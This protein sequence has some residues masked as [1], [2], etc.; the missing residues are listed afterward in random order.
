MNSNNHD[1][2]HNPPNLTFRYMGEV[3]SLSNVPTN[4]LHVGDIYHC[5]ATEYVYL[6]DNEEWVRLASII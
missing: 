2:I 3:D 1:M 5:K 6:G 4:D